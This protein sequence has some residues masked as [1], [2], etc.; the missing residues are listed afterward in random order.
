MAFLQRVE[1]Y[2]YI[3]YRHTDIWT[4]RHVGSYNV[5]PFQLCVLRSSCPGTK[6]NT[7]KTEKTDE[8]VI[9][10]WATVCIRARG[11]GIG[12]PCRYG[13]G[14]RGN[15]YRVPRLHP[16]AFLREQLRDEP[17]TVPKPLDQSRSYMNGAGDKNTC[18]RCL[19][20]R[21]KCVPT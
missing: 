15:R 2:I 13:N 20:L 17:C 1:R 5:L 19:S 4:Y 9:T 18:H 21:T 12:R 8:R 3:T 6:I 10:T 16:I 11:V 7:G 14:L